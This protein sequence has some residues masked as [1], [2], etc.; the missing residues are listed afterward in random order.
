M[1][2]NIQ[3][4]WIDA[5][6]SGLY[7]QGRLRLKGS[8]GYCCLGVACDVLTKEGLLVECPLGFKDPKTNLQHI[9]SL[10]ETAQ[11][12]LS[13]YS[14]SGD[15]KDFQTEK[16]LSNLN[17]NKTHSFADIADLLETYPELYFKNI[18]N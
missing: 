2:T 15:T 8:G 18:S 1:L 3:R 4:K 10:P 6:R 12:E 14:K 16:S 11:F 13:L 9:A 5:L 7:E 17:D